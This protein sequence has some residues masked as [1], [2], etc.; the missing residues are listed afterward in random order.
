MSYVANGTV[1]Y[2]KVGAGGA[3]PSGPVDD[4][5]AMVPLVVGSTP[6]RIVWRSTGAILTDT[7]PVQGASAQTL[8][9]S[10]FSVAGAGFDAVAD[11]PA[12]TG[13]AVVYYRVGNPTASIQ[14]VHRCK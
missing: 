14:L 11:D 13:Y 9:A 12:Q 8:D 5:D 4:V 1:F 7:F 6:Y 2:E 10:G 3:V